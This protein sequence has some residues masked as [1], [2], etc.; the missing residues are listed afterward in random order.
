[1]KFVVYRDL[2]IMFHLNMLLFILDHTRISSIQQI[3]SQMNTYIMNKFIFSF[4]VYLIPLLK[5]DQFYCRTLTA[6]EIKICQSVFADLIHY[7]QV[8]I[9]SQCFLPWQ[10]VGIIMAPCGAI[11]LHPDNYCLDFSTQPLLHRAIFIHEMAHIYQ[12]QQKI[13]VLLQGAI[14]QAG[15]YLSFKHYNPYHYQLQNQQD[16]FRYNIEQQGDIAR[17]IYLGKVENIIKNR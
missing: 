11:Y 2:D 3:L 7:D 14:L 6:G 10:P 8:K 4:L 1:M 17:D 16:Y 15:Y 12:H 13:N 5:L 9:F